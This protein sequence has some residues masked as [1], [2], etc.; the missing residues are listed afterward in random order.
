MSAALGRASKKRRTATFS[1]GA[2]RHAP[3]AARKFLPGDENSSANGETSV[4]RRYLRGS[5]RLR[6]IALNFSMFLLD[7]PL[8]QNARC[9]FKEDCRATSWCCFLRKT[10]GWVPVVAAGC[11][12]ASDERARVAACSLGCPLM[13]RVSDAG[14]LKDSAA[15]SAAGVRNPPRKETAPKGT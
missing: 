14:R 10:S 11:L 9:V 2:D 6:Q 12:W 3:N 13:C 7:A 5:T 4:R 1:A 15:G 8:G